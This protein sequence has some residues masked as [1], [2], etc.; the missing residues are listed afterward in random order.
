MEGVLGGEGE[1]TSSKCIVKFKVHTLASSLVQLR[2]SPSRVTAKSTRADSERGRE[3][4]WSPVSV[5]PLPPN[6][7]DRARDRAP[8]VPPIEPG[9]RVVME[10]GWSEGKECMEHKYDAF[11]E[12]ITDAYVTL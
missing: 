11:I 8:P 1:C 2:I 7:T 9:V 10:S 6:G 3:D 12:F 5:W 4:P